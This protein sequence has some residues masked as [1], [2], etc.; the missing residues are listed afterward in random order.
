MSTLLLFLAAS[1]LT[2]DQTATTSDG[3]RILL[4]DDGTW[5]Y[6]T[7]TTEEERNDYTFRRTKWGMAMS[8][9]I[10]SEGEE[11]AVNQDNIIGYSGTVAGLSTIIAYGSNKRL[12]F[13]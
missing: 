6:I 1:L 12:R 8:D 5:E 3:N 10:K 4:K 2:A 13:R 11:P 7:E 9:V